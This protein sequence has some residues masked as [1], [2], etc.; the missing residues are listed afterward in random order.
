MYKLVKELPINDSEV[1]YQFCPMANAGKGAYW[2]SEQSKIS[3]P[4]RG[5]S[6]PSCGSTKEV[7]KTK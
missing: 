7:L 3:N 1:F 6:M 5:K 2:L 4:Y